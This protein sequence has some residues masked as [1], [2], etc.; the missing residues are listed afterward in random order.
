MRIN[1]NDNVFNDLA[2]SLDAIFP[3][4]VTV[5]LEESNSSIILLEKEIQNKNLQK[6]HDISHKIKSS[7]KTFGAFGLTDLLEQI[8]KINDVENDELNTLFISLRIEFES[9]KNHIRTKLPL[10]KTP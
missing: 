7:S 9:V 10:I 4:I 1:F 3:E 6:I 8:E 5:F 2:A